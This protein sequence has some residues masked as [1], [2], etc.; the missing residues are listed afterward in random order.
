MNIKKLEDVIVAVKSKPRKK[1]VVAYANDSH[2]IEAVS[3]AIDL[4]IVEG[5]LV[6]DEATIKNICKEDGID[7]SKFKIVQEA[8]EQ[9]AANLAVKL[10]NDGE[11]HFIMKGLVSTD[12]YMRAILNKET[13]LLPPKAVLSHVVV[14]ELANYHKLLVVSDVAVIPAPDINQKVA[15]ANYVISTSKALGIE[16]PKIAMIAATE[17]MTASM[18]ACVDAAVISKMAD[19]GQ[20]K[21]ADVDGP[22]AL[23]V[24]IDEESVKIKKIQSAVAGNAD[25]LVFPNIESANV[26]YKSVTKLA[27]ARLGAMLVGA[28][29]PAVLTS[30]GDSAE[31]KTFSIALAALNSK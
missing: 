1:L 25:G 14:L 20:I 15:I 11:A 29:C 24:A 7:A 16:R 3:N 9:R 6:G 10:V 18:P 8:E 21:G 2:T 30:R 27:N 26:F 31:T 19:R 22:L 13:G 5:I 12:K 4:D 23:D 17:Q 28:K